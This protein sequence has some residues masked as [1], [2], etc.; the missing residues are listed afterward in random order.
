V[1]KGYTQRKGIDFEDTFAPVAR[2]TSTRVVLAIAAHYGLPVVSID[3]DNAYLN[4]VIDAKIYMTQ[5]EGYVDPDN[6]DLV[7]ELLKSLYGLKQ[8]GKIWNAAIHAYVLELGF[9]CISVDK[10]VYMKELEGGKRVFLCLHV[11]D[12]LGAGKQEDLDGFSTDMKKR[13][14]IKVTIASRHLGIEIART[15]D[16]GI[17]L[18]QSGYLSQVIALYGQSTA[19][20]KDLPMAGG[21]INALVSGTT[22][23]KALSPQEITTFRGIVGKLMYA[24]VG[25]RPD[26]SLAVSLL[27]SYASCPTTFH[28]SVAKGV[29]QYVKGTVNAHLLFP[30]GSVGEPLS[31]KGYVDASFAN[32]EGRKSTTGVAHLLNRALVGWCSK[33]Q[34]TVATSSSEAEYIALFEGTRETIWLRRLLSEI[35]CP[36]KGATPLLED[37]QACITFTRDDAPHTRT[38]HIDVKYHF[39]REKIATHEIVMQEV[40]SEDQL[41]DGFTKEQTKQRFHRDCKLLGLILQPTA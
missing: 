4:G 10:C 24:M 39:T 25:T 14:S 36:Q 2:M 22:E 11:D 3:V 19:H 8:A 1:A 30:R 5:P 13:Y 29:L 16:M 18:S 40:R 38:K 34:T 35:G 41:A 31:L 32:Q 37:N 21:V 12:F 15:A 28:M 20:P 33:K 6:P 23:G 7:C 9:I 27:G 17:Q 26:I